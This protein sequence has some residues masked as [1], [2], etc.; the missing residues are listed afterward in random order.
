ML[1]LPQEKWRW[2]QDILSPGANDSGS[3]TSEVV[4]TGHEAR[5]K[6]WVILCFFLCISDVQHARIFA[7]PRKQN[8]PRFTL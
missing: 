2:M 5:E 6:E 1:L 8:P 7:M 3:G 4:Q